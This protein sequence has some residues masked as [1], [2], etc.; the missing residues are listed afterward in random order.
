[1]DVWLKSMDVCLKALDGYSRSMDACFELMGTHYLM[2]HKR[3]HSDT[4]ELSLFSWIQAQETFNTRQNVID[5]LP[6]KK[7]PN[8][9]HC[10]HHMTCFTIT[11]HIFLLYG[12]EGTKVGIQEQHQAAECL[13]MIPNAA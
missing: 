3:L 1:M 9:P 7:K 2:S 12:D 4:N 10:L 8:M 6:K 5:V 13:F 11:P